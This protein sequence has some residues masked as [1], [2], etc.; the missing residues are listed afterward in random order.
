MTTGDLCPNCYARR[1]VIFLSFDVDGSALDSHPESQ[2]SLRFGE[3]SEVQRGRPGYFR[4]Q[5][6]CQFCSLHRAQNLSTRCRDTGPDGGRSVSNR[7]IS[8]KS[9]FGSQSRTRTCN[10]AINSRLLC[11]LSYL[12]LKVKA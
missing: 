6:N 2:G 4:A 12:G 9:I 5:G 8:K 3:R 10:L 11:Q 1:T 7:I